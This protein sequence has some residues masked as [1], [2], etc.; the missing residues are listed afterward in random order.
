MMVSAIQREDNAP[1]EISIRPVAI[2]DDIRWL[3]QWTGVAAEALTTFYE[4]TASGSFMQCMM[5]WENEQPILQVDIC[6]ALFDDLGAGDAVGPGDY[7]LRLQF[8]PN[9]ADSSI[10]RGLYNCLDYVFVTRKANR[11]LIPVYKSNHMLLE[12]VKEAH[13]TLS[14]GTMNTPLHKLY[15]LTKAS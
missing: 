6:E 14:A 7:T 1:A 4:N 15:M 9:A 10:W 8:A 2:P 3:Q 12:W 11:I 5:V 13:F